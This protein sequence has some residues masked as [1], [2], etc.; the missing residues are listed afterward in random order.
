MEV[1]MKAQ[2]RWNGKVLLP[3]DIIDVD[4]SV[5]S[6]WISHNIA[7]PIQRSSPLSTSP[8]EDDDDTPAVMDY[9]EMKIN[10]LRKLAKE[11]NITFTAKT[12]KGELI[13]FLD[14]AGPETV[15]TSQNFPENHGNATDKPEKKSP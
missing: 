7:E 5:G 14:S 12:K 15:E 8:I 13:V 6:R 3:G 1:R 4:T 2:T 11:K 10:D 9:D